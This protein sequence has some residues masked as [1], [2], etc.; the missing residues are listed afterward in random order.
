MERRK[1]ARKDKGTVKES[2]GKE[3]NCREE[4]KRKMG[5][6]RRKE[7]KGKTERR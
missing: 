5:G 7:G 4:K 1:N 3:G 6:I 2:G